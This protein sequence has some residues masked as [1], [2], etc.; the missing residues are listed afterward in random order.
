MMNAMK[1]VSVGSDVAI[2]DDMACIY[3]EAA[4]K[5]IWRVLDVR[6]VGFNC[7]FTLGILAD[8]LVVEWLTCVFADDIHTVGI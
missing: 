8:G 2:N 7:A 1:R 4:L 5:K 6:G 3:G